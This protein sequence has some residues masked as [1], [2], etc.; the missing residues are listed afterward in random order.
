VSV[1]SL[2]VTVIHN[3]DEVLCDVRNESEQTTF[4]NQSAVSMKYEMSSKKRSAESIEQGW[5]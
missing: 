1:L 2:A 4:I 3:R 5:L